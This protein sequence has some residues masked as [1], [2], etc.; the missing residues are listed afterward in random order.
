MAI[1]ALSFLIVPLIT[2]VNDSREELA[3]RT[4]L[5]AS[6]E[7]AAG[8][9]ITTTVAEAADMEALAIQLNNIQPAAG[10]ESTMPGL[11]EEFSADF[12]SKQHPAF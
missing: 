7:P 12:E 6:I 11:P 8:D 9:E 5:M 4:S 3:A 10:E 1:V 2:G